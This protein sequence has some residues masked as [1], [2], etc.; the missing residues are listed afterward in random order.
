MPSL[1]LVKVCFKSVFVWMLGYHIVNKLLG[2][3]TTLAFSGRRYK[4]L[5]DSKGFYL[6]FRSYSDRWT[7]LSILGISWYIESYYYESVLH[8]LHPPVSCMSIY[9]HWPIYL[10]HLG[11]PGWT[12]FAFWTALILCGIDSTRCWKL[13]SEI[14]VHIDLIA[15]RSCCRFIGCTS[16][17]WISRSTTSQSCSIGLRS[18]DCGGHLSKVNSLSYSRNQSE[19]IWALWHGA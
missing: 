7:L 19:M 5:H 4:C 15:S 2:F 11:T 14:L 13:S 1:S 8:F 12:P 6:L 16:M 18:D 17:M 3:I 9:T 10:V